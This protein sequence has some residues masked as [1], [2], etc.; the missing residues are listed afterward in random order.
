MHRQNKKHS[1][2]GGKLIEPF[3]PGKDTVDDNVFIREPA[4]TPV[5]PELRSLGGCTLMNSKE[6]LNKCF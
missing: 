4:A 6:E 3:Q 2:L 1:E 5:Q